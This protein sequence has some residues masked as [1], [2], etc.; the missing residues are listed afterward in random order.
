MDTRASPRFLSVY[1]VKGLCDINKDLIQRDL[2]LNA[3]FLN[4]TSS[5]NH[6]GCPSHHI[7]F[8][9]FSY[10]VHSE[11]ILKYWTTNRFPSFLALVAQCLMLFVGL[12]ALQ[13]DCLD[14]RLATVY[15]V[16]VSWRVAS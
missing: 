1:D 15:K 16:H 13:G 10:R 6:I 11:F 8:L 9:N 14:S 5:K 12:F 3:F 2:L 4:L 7:E